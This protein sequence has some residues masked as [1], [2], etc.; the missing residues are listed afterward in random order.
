VGSTNLDRAVQLSEI[1]QETLAA[2]LVS[3]LD[4]L[5]HLESITLNELELKRLNNGNNI[6]NEGKDNQSLLIFDEHSV[7]RGIAWRKDNLLNPKV[8]I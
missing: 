6:V 7:C 4:I 1:S 3:A 8:N 5:S 2:H